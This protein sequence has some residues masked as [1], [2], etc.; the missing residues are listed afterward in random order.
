MFSKDI[1]TALFC[2]PLSISVTA[3]K[4]RVVVIFGGG[5]GTG[6]SF[7]SADVNPLSP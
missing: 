6:F 1:A 7:V 5:P 2:V 4:E 3:E